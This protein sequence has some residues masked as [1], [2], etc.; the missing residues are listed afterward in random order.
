MTDPNRAGVRQFLL[1]TLS[2]F[3]AA[4][5]RTVD[6][7][8]LTDDRDLLLSGLID[9]LGFLELASALSEYCGFELDFESLDPED[10][11]VLGPLCDFV[12]TQLAAQ[13]SR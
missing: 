13:Q 1:K 9:S 3:F 6:P 11:T 8:L 4:Q 7:D 5:G 12:A 2:E 10:M